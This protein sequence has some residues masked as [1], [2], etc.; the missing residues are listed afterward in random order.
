[1]LSART[2]GGHL[3]C[4]VLTILQARPRPL[5]PAE[6]PQAEPNRR[7]RGFYYSEHNVLMQDSY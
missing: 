3:Y 6:R 1:M 5:A 4:A 2:L 7:P